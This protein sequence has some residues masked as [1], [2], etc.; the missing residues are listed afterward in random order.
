MMTTA[1]KPDML[2]P[3]IRHEPPSREVLVLED[4]LRVAL[5]LSRLLTMSGFRVCVA[6]DADQA[7]SLIQGHE[8]AFGIIIA[9]YGMRGGEDGLSFLRWASERTPQT[10][11]ILISGLDL[12]ELQDQIQDI[13][14][15]FLTKPFDRA[16]LQEALAACMELEP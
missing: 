10:R 14:H 3:D 2:M 11:R 6:R 5:A 13:C 15:I 8:R 16:R 9:D 1:D 4:E 7:R 12:I